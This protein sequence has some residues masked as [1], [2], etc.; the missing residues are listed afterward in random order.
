MLK[1][2]TDAA[3]KGNPGKSAAG[4]LI[5]TE[6]QQ[7]QLKEPLAVMTNH[8]AEFMAAISGFKKLKELFGKQQTV[9]FYT[10]SQIVINSL[11]KKYSKSYQP[12]LDELIHLQADFDLVIFQW[13]PEKQNQGAHQLALQA[14]KKA[15]R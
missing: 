3:T 13:L 8:E 11:E 1:L 9:F 6:T 12:L 5:V 14:L 7:L 15:T 10:D 4:I 2:Y